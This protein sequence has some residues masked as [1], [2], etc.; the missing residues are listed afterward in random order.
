MTR[1]GIV[2]IENSHVD[3]F[4]RFLNA[5]QRYP[6]VRVVGLVRGEESRTEVV[7]AAAGPDAE[8]VDDSTALVGGIDAAI[9]CSRDGARHLDDALPLLSAGIPVLVDKPLAAT[10]ADAQVLIAAARD[11]AVPLVSASAVRHAPEVAK[12]LTNLTGP[13]GRLGERQAVSVAGPADPASEYS[14]LFFY[15]IHVV[16][17]ALE[18][19]GD[20]DFAPVTARQ[21][22]HSILAT[23]IINGAHVTMTFVTADDAGQIPFHA[24]VTG[25]HGIESSRLTLGPDYNAPLLATFMDA[26]SSGTAPADDTTLLR[27]VQLLT[28]IIEAT[29]AT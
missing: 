8:V 17:T 26:V 6:G 27:P 24:V 3:H 12:L 1:I 13:A 15:G 22:G 19:V 7:R 2:G 21:T 29:R 11:H 18:L 20:G 23:T 14:G 4:V 5:E 9:V 10:V 25:R 16:E 28:A